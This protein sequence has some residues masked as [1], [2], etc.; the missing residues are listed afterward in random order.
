MKTLISTF[1]LLAV[2]VFWISCASTTP[3]TPEMTLMSDSAEGA[4]GAESAFDTAEGGTLTDDF[5]A[6]GALP[7]RDEAFDA[8]DADMEA[9]SSI[10]FD[11]DR[12]YVR[13][14]ERPVVEET[15]AFLVA[16]PGQKVL[17]EGHCDWRGTTE[18]NLALGDRRSNSV[19]D[20]L[21]ELGVAPMTVEILSKG[22]LEADENADE[23]GRQNDR[24]ADIILLP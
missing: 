4:T 19:K 8:E 3:P 12:A 18:Y 17:I 22:D 11:F 21:V 1:C 10:Y 13:E 16:N 24:R 23:M 6:E 20:Y 15:A 2:S 5:E 9:Y 14:S 7:V